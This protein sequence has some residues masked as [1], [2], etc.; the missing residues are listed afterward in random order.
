MPRFSIPNSTSLH[1]VHH[2]LEM[3]DFFGGTE[4]GAELILHPRWMHI[5]PYGLAMAAA[6]GAWCRRNT[7]SITVRN[8]G[9]QARYAARMKLF[10]HLRIDPGFSIVEHEEA[11]RFLPLRKVSTALDI[12]GVIADL[13]ALLHLDRF[14]DALAAVQY[15]VSELLRNA[16]EHAGSP[17]GAFVCAHNYT[18]GAN[19]RVSIA[20]A[21]CGQGIASH[22]GSV[23]PDVRGDDSRALALAMLPGVTGVQ[24]GM[25]GTPDNAGAGLFITR[26]IAKGSGGYFVMMSGRAAYRLRRAKGRS[27]S[28]RIVLDPLEERHDLWNLP[29]GWQ[30]TVVAVEIRTNQIKDFQR[31]FR[32]IREQIP[33]P[34]AKRPK[35]RFT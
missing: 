14:P 19:R 30:G 7:A 21:D 11:G 33:R 26:C 9:P 25:Y 6:W 23:Y 32:W 12:R 4:T 35:I 15:C 22:L 5:E 24:P 18:S 27:R 10:E 34:A 8:V 17:D 31:F 28:R 2:L 13:S 29:A 3:N 20:V 16:L 1:T